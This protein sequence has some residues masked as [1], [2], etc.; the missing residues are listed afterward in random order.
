MREDRIREELR[1]LW[2]KLIPKDES[3]IP[4]ITLME[5]NFNSNG[6]ILIYKLGE[7]SSM[8][9]CRENVERE[10][11]GIGEFRRE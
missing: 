11:F 9:V 7:K 4:W 10:I 1:A 3:H 2:V 5:E 8:E 6:E